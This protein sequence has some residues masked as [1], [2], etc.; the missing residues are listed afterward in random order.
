MNTKAVG[1][2]PRGCVEIPRKSK[3]KVA[4][5]AVP[6]HLGPKPPVSPFPR[7]IQGGHPI[8]ERAGAT[9]QHLVCQ[10]GLLTEARSGSGLRWTGT[11]AR[12]RNALKCIKIVDDVRNINDPIRRTRPEVYPL[13]WRRGRGGYEALEDG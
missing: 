1:E 3:C 9:A 13:E 6:D 5:V 4:S 12:I 11:R 10:A 7:G 8:C 2:N